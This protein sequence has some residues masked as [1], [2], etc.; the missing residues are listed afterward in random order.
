MNLSNS[1]LKYGRFPVKHPVCYTVKFKLQVKVKC[2]AQIWNKN[3]IQQCAHKHKGWNKG[4][5]AHAA[6]NGSNT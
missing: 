5:T 1:F 3:N 6:R 2:S 4:N